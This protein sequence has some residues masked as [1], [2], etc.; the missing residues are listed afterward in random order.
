MF[1]KLHTKLGAFI[2]ASIFAISL[3]AEVTLTQDEIDQIHSKI[4][5]MS[6][7]ELRTHREFL[8]NERK[9]LLAADETT[10]LP[11]K[12]SWNSDISRQKSNWHK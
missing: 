1:Y 3:S 2:M 7:S 11:S 12:K 10:Q 4:D 6:V 8:L 5:A 9:E